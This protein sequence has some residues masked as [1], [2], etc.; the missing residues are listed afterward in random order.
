MVFVCGFVICAWW[1]KIDANYEYDRDLLLNQE[2]PYQLVWFN[3][4]FGLCMGTD[5][6]HL[7]KFIVSRH[8]LLGNVFGSTFSDSFR[9]NLSSHPHC[10][11]ILQSTSCLIWDFLT[12]SWGCLLTL[13]LEICVPDDKVDFSGDNC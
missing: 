7:L 1:C 4:W 2:T 13:C 3:A 6:D 11:V 5:E 9:Q 10:K 8:Q 12:S